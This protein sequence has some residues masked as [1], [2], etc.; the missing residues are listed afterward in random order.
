ML[1]PQSPLFSSLAYIEMQ[2]VIATMLLRYDIK[3]ESNYLD[4]TEGF[5]HKPL[6][7]MVEVKRKDSAC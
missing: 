3:L 4:T 1:T 5:M 7:M 2:L 6:R